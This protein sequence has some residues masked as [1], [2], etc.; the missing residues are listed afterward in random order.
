MGQKIQPFLHQRQKNR[1]HA[2]F[3]LQIARKRQFMQRLP[4]AL[5]LLQG[6]SGLWYEDFVG[7]FWN[8]WGLRVQNRSGEVFWGVF[9]VRLRVFSRIA[10][11]S[12]PDFSLRAGP[13]PCLLLIY[14]SGLSPTPSLP[15]LGRENLANTLSWRMREGGFLLY[16][17]SFYD[18]FLFLFYNPYTERI[19]D[20]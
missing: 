5:A 4:L 18:F 14:P 12:G 17:K 15:K 20:E 3:H 11:Y 9:E 13:H 10:P 16:H 6:L 8:A 7:K 19:F 1:R 2:A